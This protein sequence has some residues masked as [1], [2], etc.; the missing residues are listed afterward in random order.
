MTSDY[1]YGLRAMS[2]GTGALQAPPAALEDAIA[3]NRGPGRG[4]ADAG[5]AGGFDGS[6]GSPAEARDDCA[7][8]TDGDAA[9]ADTFTAGGDGRASAALRAAASPGALRS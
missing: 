7:S 2:S 5:S 6:A 4:R 8:A 1:R 3:G 9:R